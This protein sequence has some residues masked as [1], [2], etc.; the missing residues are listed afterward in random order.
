MFRGGLVDAAVSVVILTCAATFA[1]A[2]ELGEQC[3]G[4][5]GIPC[6][7]GLW[8]DPQ[9][10]LCRGF[11]IPGTCVIIPSACSQIAKPV[12][13]CDD[14]QYTSDCER[15]KSLTAKRHNGKC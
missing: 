13:A 9:P 15:Q 4:I 11:D 7:S 2:A 5:V 8:C 10:G 14:S 6:D 1:N 12:C 3:G